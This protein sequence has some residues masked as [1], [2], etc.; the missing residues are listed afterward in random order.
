ML[1]YL[2]FFQILFLSISVIDRIWP[3]VCEMFSPWLFPYYPQ[4]LPNLPANWIRQFNTPILLPWS[5]LY[6]QY[7]QMMLHSFINCIQFML[8]TFPASD[9]I[10]SNIFYWYE[11]NFGNVAVP[12]HVLLPTHSSLILLPWNRLKPTPLNITGFHRL[13]QQVNSNPRHKGNEIID[14]FFIDPKKFQYLPDCHSFLGHIFLRVNW[15]PWLYSNIHQWDYMTR[16]RIL[17]TLLLMF[18][19]LSYE[20]NVRENLQ[21]LTLLQ[22]AISFPWYMLDYQGIEGTFDWYVMSTEPSSILCLNSEHSAVDNS[23]LR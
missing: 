16:N 12:R 11:T 19:K 10:L 20:P 8:D 14:V 1:H 6:S 21:L 9:L 17:A 22:E 4:N 2:T 15:T 3:S 13:L 7:S 18:V 5:E 23:I